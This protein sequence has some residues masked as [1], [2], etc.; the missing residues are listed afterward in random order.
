LLLRLVD[1]LH[2]RLLFLWLTLLPF[3]QRPSHH[4]SVPTALGNFLALEMKSWDPINIFLLPPL[5]THVLDVDVLQ[6]ERPL[7]MTCWIKKYSFISRDPAYL[8][9]NFGK[10]SLGN[11]DVYGEKVVYLVKD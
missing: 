2:L 5:L 10:L 3:L 7:W 4:L 9:T 6:L 11:L 1:V 8:L